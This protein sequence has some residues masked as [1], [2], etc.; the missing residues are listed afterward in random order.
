MMCFLL[1]FFGA[2][3]ESLKGFVGVVSCFHS[4]S[5]PGASPQMKV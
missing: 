5:H 2:F 3:I 1:V 4:A